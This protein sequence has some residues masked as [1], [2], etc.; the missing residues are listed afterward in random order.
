MKSVKIFMLVI[1]CLMNLFMLIFGVLYASIP[2]QI[3][4]TTGSWWS[5]AAA[6]LW[7][8]AVATFV[9]HCVK[10]MNQLYKSDENEQDEDSN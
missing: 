10:S 2:L 4:I 5:L 9:F 7:Y 1:L 3:Y 8:A 6:L